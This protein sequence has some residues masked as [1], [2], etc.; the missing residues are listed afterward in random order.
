MSVYL[1]Y[2]DPY[3]VADDMI[4]GKS[5]DKADFDARAVTDAIFDLV[6]D[7]HADAQVMTVTS[8]NGHRGQQLL[9]FPNG[10]PL[11]KKRRKN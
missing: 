8:T 4:Q 6:K 2:D 10:H 9:F 1:H 5:R 3:K 7:T 11:F